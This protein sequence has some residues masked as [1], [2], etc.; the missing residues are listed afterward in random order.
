M[1]FE[2]EEGRLSA[3]HDL[4]NKLDDRLESAKVDQIGAGASAKALK[5]T[6]AII[7]SLAN[8]V[9]KDRDE[10]TI[11]TSPLEVTEYAIKMLSRAANCVENKA[12]QMEAQKL[13]AGGL[14]HG[15]NSIISQFKKQY[16]TESTSLNHLRKDVEDGNLEIIGNSKVWKGPPGQRPPGTRPSREPIGK[17]RREEEAKPEDVLG[18]ADRK[19]S[20]SA[21]K[22][23]RPS[24][25][26]E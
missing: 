7:A 18:L 17:R 4:G 8:L 19:V 21:S 16:E 11:P 5:E 10:G 14:I 1:V 25:K 9:K 12:L 6:V 20:K 13:A 24:K 2:R 23:K 22:K 15:L 3:I 26:E